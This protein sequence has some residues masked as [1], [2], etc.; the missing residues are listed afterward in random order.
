MARYIA[1]YLVRTLCHMTLSSV[2]RE[3]GFTSYSTVNTVT[4]KINHRKER[5]KRLQKTLDEISNIIRV[6]HKSQ[7]PT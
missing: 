5:D 6:R 2:G 4:Q 1:V 7:Q 3:F